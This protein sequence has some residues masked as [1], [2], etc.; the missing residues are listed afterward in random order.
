MFYSCSNSYTSPDIETGENINIFPDYTNVVFPVNIAPSNFRILSEGE[1]YQVAFGCGNEILYNIVSSEPDIIISEDEWKNLLNKSAG[2][3][4]FYRISVRKNGKWYGY[5]DINNYISKDSI[6]R[7]LTYRL[8]Y[9]GY[10]LWNEMGVYQRDLSSFSVVPLIENK[11]IDGQ[12]INCHSFNRN[13]VNDFMLHVRGNKGGTIVLKDDIK[14]KVNSLPEGAKMGATYTNWHPSGKYIAF[15]MNNIQQF[16]HSFGKKQIEVV[17]LDAD[18]GVY[19]IYNY[20]MLTCEALTDTLYMDTFPAWSPDGKYLYFCRASALKSL[21]DIENVRYDLFRITFDEEKKVFS[22]P[23]CVYN[24][25]SI[26]KSVSFPRLSPSGKYLMFTQSDYGNFSIWHTE[27]DLILMDLNNGVSRCIDE[28]NSNNVDSYH[29]W[30]D[31]GKWFVFS[32]KRFDGLWAVPFISY[33]DEESGMA[34]KPF[35]LPQK[36]PMFYKTFMYTFNIPEFSNRIFKQ[37]EIIKLVE[38]EKS[39]MKFKIVN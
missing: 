5:N 34:S 8:L 3:N 9:P 33:F 10:E 37:E 27:S 22:T 35:P 7:Y 20:K 30:S 6:D 32:S 11:N 24:A 17:D 26:S 16:F 4:V 19:D 12:C 25:S 36:D 23:E 31:T 39:S 38:G 15:S 28:V 18:L 21:D 1:K 29:S 13:N 2:Q 14:Y